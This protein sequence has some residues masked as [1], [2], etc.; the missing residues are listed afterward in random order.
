MSIVPSET[1]T[2]LSS[3]SSDRSVSWPSARTRESAASRS[4]RPVGCGKPL[5]SSSICS[6][7][8]PSGSTRSMV[9][10]QWN[11]HALLLGLGDLLVVGRHPVAGAPVD[12][13][14]VGGAQATGGAG[15]VDG[16]VAA[17]VD[18]DPAAQQRPLALLEAVQQGD[19]V[20]HASGRGG[21]QVGALAELRADGQDDG[22]PAL[23]TGRLDVGHRGVQLE[24]D[25]ERRAAGRSPRPA[26]RAG[27]GSAGCR[28]A[29]SRRRAA[30]SRGRRPR[31][32]AG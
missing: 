10:S 21:G 7:I 23:V 15:R 27:A 17:A 32:R 11:S 12:D 5:S 25:T 28:S 20:D 14:G 3:P 13:H 31:A 1:A 4:M 6:I 9:E 22:V 2:P 24:A 26:P 30:P 18:R 29:S 16:G 19:R 8:S